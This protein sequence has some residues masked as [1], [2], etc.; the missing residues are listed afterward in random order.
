MKYILVAYIKSEALLKS[1]EGI[2]NY[3]GL[4]VIEDNSYYRM[5]MGYCHE[6]PRTFTELLFKELADEEFDKEDTLSLI[7][8]KNGQDVSNSLGNIVLK[9][10]GNLQ[11][12]R[13]NHQS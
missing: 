13:R 3:Y 5:L 2:A 10:K 9:R 6:S 4:N 11:L 8:T 12:R 1:I 7:Y